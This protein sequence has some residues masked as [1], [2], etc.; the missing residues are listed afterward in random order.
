MIE[1]IQGI[2]LIKSSTSGSRVR[3]L[4]KSFRILKRDSIRLEEAP[5]PR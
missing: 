1:Y 2:R 5:A 3:K 4:E